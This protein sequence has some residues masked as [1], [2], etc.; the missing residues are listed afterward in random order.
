MKIQHYLAP[1]A[2]V[3]RL[4]PESIICGSLDGKGGDLEIVDPLNPWSLSEDPFNN[5]I[6]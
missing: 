2:E 1:E 4:F 6:F 5:L 3:I